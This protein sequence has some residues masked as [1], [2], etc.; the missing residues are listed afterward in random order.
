[1]KC[2]IC[3]LR[4]S[5]V[6]NYSQNKQAWSDYQWSLQPP[7]VFESI[8]IKVKPTQSNW[9]V[10]LFVPVQYKRLWSRHEVGGQ[11]AS[12]KLLFIYLLCCGDAGSLPENILCKE[13]LWEFKIQN[14]FSFLSFWFFPPHKNP[15]SS[16][17]FLCTALDSFMG[18]ADNA[19]WK[20]VTGLCG[21]YAS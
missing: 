5:I 8:Q 17:L 16:A 20:H 4:L 19:V 13:E 15:L 14:P 6:V 11:Q 2:A 7:S 10:Q 18:W 3:A 1:M 12:T 9:N 21:S